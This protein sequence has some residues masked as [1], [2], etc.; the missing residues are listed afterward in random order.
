MND[1]EAGL[2][3]SSHE[4]RNRM[5]KDEWRQLAADNKKDWLAF[6]DL[7]GTHLT[8]RKAGSGRW[9]LVSEDGS[10]WA[11][12]KG[13]SV[14]ASDRHYEIKNVW[15][16]GKKRSLSGLGLVRRELVDSSGTVALSW[17][18]QHYGGSAG[19]VLSLGGVE[20]AFPIR[21][22]VYKTKNVMSAVEVGGSNSPIARFRLT[23]GFSRTG[24]TWKY[25]PPRSVEV[26]IRRESLPRPQM[27]LTVAVASSWL[28]SYFR[29]G[30]G[31]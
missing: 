19:T 15:T 25:Y 20:Y 23:T 21:G 5:S 24:T 27:A 14:S 16:D 3:E 7:P 13:W 18:G 26:V 4:I 17:T 31:S 8:W 28:R 11:S 9:D 1:S 29:A 22:S 6:P 2:A 30:G 12:R 10:L